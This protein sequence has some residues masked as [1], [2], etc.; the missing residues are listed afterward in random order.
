MAKRLSSDDRASISLGFFAAVILALLLAMRYLHWPDLHALDSDR[1]LWRNLYLWSAPADSSDGFF[2]NLFV[3]SAGS[4]NNAKGRPSRLLLGSLVLP[5]GIT[6]ILTA[7]ARVPAILPRVGV[8]DCFLAA[9]IGLTIAFFF[10]DGISTRIWRNLFAR[11]VDYA[12]RFVPLF[13]TIL[14]LVLAGF[15]GW[16][17]YSRWTKHDYTGGMDIACLGLGLVS[18]AV[19]G[20]RQPR[21][22]SVVQA[23]A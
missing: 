12:E 2:F 5:A 16:E 11:N 22:A 10:I 13:G 6:G 17:L 9:I 3:L 7:A 1:P 4:V 15:W 21:Q 20:K 18:A 19:M 14:C 23:E 8:A